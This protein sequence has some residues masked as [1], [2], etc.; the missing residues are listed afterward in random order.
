MIQFPEDRGH[1]ATGRDHKQTG[2]DWR[3]EPV[4]DLTAIEEDFKGCGAEADEGYADPIDPQFAVARANRFALFFKGW[5]IVNK[6]AG[7]IDG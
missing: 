7:E 3:A 6:A 4:V 1:E 5:R 2:D